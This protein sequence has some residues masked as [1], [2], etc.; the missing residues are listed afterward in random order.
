MCIRSDVY[1]FIDSSNGKCEH[2]KY[3]RILNGIQTTNSLLN[4]KCTHDFGNTAIKIEIFL[5]NE[6]HFWCDYKQ[7]LYEMKICLLKW[8]W[9]LWLWKQDKNKKLKKYVHFDSV[10]KKTR[11]IPKIN[12]FRSIFFLNK[13]K[14]W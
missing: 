12:F 6:Q 8:V 13:P 4:S 2:F 9:L 14:K 3:H 5:K 10:G 1:E 7:L 11:K